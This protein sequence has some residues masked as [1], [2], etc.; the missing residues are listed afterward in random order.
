[1]YLR[2]ALDHILYDGPVLNLPTIKGPCLC[3]LYV[4]QPE[5][6]GQVLDVFS[7]HPEREISLMELLNLGLMQLVRHFGQDHTHLHVVRNSEAHHEMLTSMI[8]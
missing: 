2:Q 6:A 1:M 5:A 7:I 4:T 3:A 8:D